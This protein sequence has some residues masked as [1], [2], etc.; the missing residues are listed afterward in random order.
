MRRLLS[1]QTRDNDTEAEDEWFRQKLSGMPSESLPSGIDQALA[2]DTVLASDPMG[3][4]AIGDGTSFND[5]LWK[6]ADNRRKM[7]DYC[8]ELGIIMGLEWDMERCY[9]DNQ[10]GE[11]VPD[12]DTSTSYAEEG[13]DWPH[14]VTVFYTIGPQ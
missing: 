7:L 13:T 3:Y 5:A 4:H 1:S 10:P 6:K 8:P 14:A 9:D 12:D 2:V 11:A